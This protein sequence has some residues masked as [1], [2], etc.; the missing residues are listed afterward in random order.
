MTALR[1]AIIDLRTQALERIATLKGMR[2]ERVAIRNLAERMSD[3][4]VLA[5]LRRRESP[6]AA[7]LSFFLRR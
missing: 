3:R 6:I 1:E 2:A 4:E 5:E 7:V